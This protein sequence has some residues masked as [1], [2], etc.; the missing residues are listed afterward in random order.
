VFYRTA[1]SVYAARV[2]LGPA[3]RIEPGRALFAHDSYYIGYEAVWDVSPDGKRFVFVKL[4]DEGTTLNLMLNWI[5]GWRGRLPA[6][7]ATARRH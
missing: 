7:A 3:P 2:T 4:D 1:D 6:R 5:P